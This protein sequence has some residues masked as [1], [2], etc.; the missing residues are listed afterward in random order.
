IAAH[1]NRMVFANWLSNQ[2]IPWMRARYQLPNDPRKTTALGS[3]AG[4]LAAAFI[5][6]MRPEVVG[7]GVSLSGALWR[8]A[9]AKASPPW[10]WLTEQVSTGQ[11]RD[12]RLVLDV[13]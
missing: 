10:E 3:S 6:L 5:A 9:E 13:G 12:A 8:T 4:G 1:G 2:L 7:N 11:K